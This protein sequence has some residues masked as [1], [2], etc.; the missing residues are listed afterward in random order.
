MGTVEGEKIARVFRKAIR[1]KAPAIVISKSGGARMQEGSLSLMQMAKTSAFIAQM[2]KK[3]L[4]YISIITNP[5]TGGVS[6]SFAMLGDV[7]IAEPRALIGF[8]G[9]R[10]IR[11]TIRESLP[12]NFQK[13]ELLLEKG[14]LD[15]I[16]Q[17]DELKSTV[18]QLL[19]H[20]M[21]KKEWPAG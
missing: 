9:A 8:A 13:S 2:E 6:A 21:S 20:F 4:P 17:R 10:V 18:F 1:L 12:P 11:E 3:K 14:F 16:V 15:M 7:N 19:N 5:T